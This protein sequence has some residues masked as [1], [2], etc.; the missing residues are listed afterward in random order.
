MAEPSPRSPFPAGA[1]RSAILALAALLALGGCR[2]DGV[3]GIRGGQERADRGAEPGQEDDG[4]S[5]RGTG[6]GDDIVF[7]SLPQN[8]KPRLPPGL[9]DFQQVF[10]DVAEK[11][12]PAVVSI[13]SERNVAQPEG[14]SRYDDFLDNGPFQYFFGLPESKAPNPRQHK[15]TGLGSGV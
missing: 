11:A 4:P 8:E 6:P 7:D 13:Y 15:E 2:R 1:P 12:I 3:S 10:A 9:K 14:G 5:G